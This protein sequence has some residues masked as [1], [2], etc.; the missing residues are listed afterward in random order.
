MEKNCQKMKLDEVRDLVDW[1]RFDA[2]DVDFVLYQDFFKVCQKLFV[3]S[4]SYSFMVNLMNFIWPGDDI[5]CFRED[6][7]DRLIRFEMFL[8]EF[9][10]V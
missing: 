8:E 10:D 5:Y 3:S 4:F 1:Y 9:T 7:I 2:P 6:L